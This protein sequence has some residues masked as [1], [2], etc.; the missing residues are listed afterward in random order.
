MSILPSSRCPEMVMNK[1]CSGA[2]LRHAT[3]A[4][5]Q[6]ELAPDK[7][8]FRPRGGG[9]RLTFGVWRRRV[10]DRGLPIPSALSAWGLMAGC[11]LYG[12]LLWPPRALTSLPS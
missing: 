11:G 5:M 1:V 10:G 12:F 7:I 6:A 9:N 4:C 2:R 8:F 3:N